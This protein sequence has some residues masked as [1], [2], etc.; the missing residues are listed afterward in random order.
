MI[1]MRTTPLCWSISDYTVTSAF[2]AQN[3][4]VFKS[5]Y[6]AATNTTATWFFYYDA[7]SRLSEIRYT[8]NAASPSNYT[9]YELV[10]LGDEL[11]AYWQTDYPSVTTSKSYV[12]RDES[13]RPIDMM[14]WPATGDAA[15]VWAI[16]PDAWGNDTV[17][18]PGFQPIVFAGQY[19]DQETTAHSGS[20]TSSP[21]RRRSAL[22]LNGYRTYD[23]WT[24]SYLQVDPLVDSTWSSYVY[25]D[26]NPVE[27]SDPLGL[28][29][30]DITVA[31]EG[32]WGGFCM[33]GGMPP[34]IEGG[35]ETAST[36]CHDTFAQ[37][38]FWDQMCGTFG[39]QQSKDEGE[40]PTPTA[41]DTTTDAKAAKDRLCTKAIGGELSSCVGDV[42]SQR[43][44]CSDLK[45]DSEYQCCCALQYEADAAKCGQKEISAR[46]ACDRAATNTF[47]ACTAI[48]APG[49]LK[50]CEISSSCR[51][52]PKTPPK[53]FR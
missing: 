47:N 32:S 49:T 52:S 3:R 34:G 48:R 43:G 51:C 44:R 9:V 11:V 1:S 6:R 13:G 37:D 2:D 27:K 38:V 25:V 18:V 40:L 20:S 41:P 50:T 4:R 14:S 30:V 42:L 21:K 29:K 26:S 23:P 24:G 33:V 12:G 5:Y 36:G 53:T 17:L 15:R 46:P 28:L 16:N 22:V 8:P 39:C 35:S 45:I 31:V 19:Q 10:W 7:L